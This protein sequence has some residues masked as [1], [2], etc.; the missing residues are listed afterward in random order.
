MLKPLDKLTIVHLAESYYAV[1]IA[2]LYDDNLSREEV[3][4]VVASAIYS[5]LPP[6]YVRSEAAHVATLQKCRPALF[7]KRLRD[8]NEAR[9]ALDLPPL[10]MSA[11]QTPAAEPSRFPPPPWNRPTPIEDME[12]GGVID[13]AG[14]VSSDADS[15]L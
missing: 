9:A 6:A 8:H 1:Q 15:G 5:D 4:G 2:N 3:L 14:N 12:I 13:A 11:P 10:V 7:A